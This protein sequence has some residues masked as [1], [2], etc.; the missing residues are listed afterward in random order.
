MLVLVQVQ[1]LLTSQRL[2]M[3]LLP[4]PLCL[5]MVASPAMMVP[6][7]QALPLQWMSMWL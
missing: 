2:R 7:C 3:L 1:L 5:L 6:R 4:P